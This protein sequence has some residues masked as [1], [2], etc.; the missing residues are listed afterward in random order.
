M[1]V[2]CSITLAGSKMQAKKLTDGTK[3][4]DCGKPRI[5]AI[6]SPGSNIV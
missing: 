6:E 5:I 1:S 3:L 2:A 4:N